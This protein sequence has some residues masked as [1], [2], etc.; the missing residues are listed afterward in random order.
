MNP[1][2]R[3][4]F[5]LLSAATAWLSSGC[6]KADPIALD[7]R[8]PAPEPAPTVSGGGAEPK[9]PPHCDALSLVWSTQQDFIHEL[10]VGYRAEAQRGGHEP[11][12]GEG[13]W[14]DLARRDWEVQRPVGPG[15]FDSTHW[16]TVCYRIEGQE[17]ATWFVD[18]REKKIDVQQRRSATNG[19]T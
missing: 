19:A 16:F 11:V 17:L 3:R 5:F 10:E 8:G 2:L 7:T 6:R 15:I 4:R 9:M 12:G 13:W 18:T 14:F 1:T